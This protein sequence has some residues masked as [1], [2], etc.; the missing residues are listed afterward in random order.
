MALNPFFLNGTQSEQGLVQ[1]LINEQLRMYGIEC[2]YMP[3]S[4]VTS[5]TVLQEVIQSEF[6]SAFPLEAYMDNY[7]GYLGQG[8]ILSKF[9]IEDKDDLTLIISRERYEN[10]IAPL[11]KM[12]EDEDKFE[13][14]DRPKEGDLIYFPLGERLFEIKFVEHEKPFYQLKKNYVYTLTCELFRY[15]D[16]LIDTDI[17]EIDDEVAQIGYIQTLTMVGGGTTATAVASYCASG[18]VSQIY[19]KNM[20]KKYTK[21]PIVG[22]T[23][24]PDG[25][26]TASGIASITNDY[27][28]C[29]GLYGGMIDAILLTNAGCGYTVPPMVTIQS[30]SGDTG[31]GAAVT[32]GITTEGNVRSVQVLSGGTGYTSAPTVTFNYSGSQPTGFVTATGISTIS[33]AGI[34][35][36][37][38]ITNSGNRYGSNPTVVLSDPPSFASGIGTTNYIFNEVI[39]GETSGTTARVK[40]WNIT[41]NLLEV[42]IVDGDF[43]PGEVV[44]GGE[45][46]ARFILGVQQEYDLVSG[47][48]DNDT[49]ELEAKDIIDFTQQNPFGMP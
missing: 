25:G 15:E 47:F 36:A 40:E 13:L 45:S 34:V 37:I 26:I 38:Y 9:G 39:T 44:V 4:Y 46:G 31:V 3:R 48:A 22:F 11:M 30:A 43:T 7:E 18:S 29:N 20:G 16:E 19:I 1:S 14:S 24:A 12:F 6:K 2:Y 5:K 49:I 35:T 23:S 8:T 33:A 17:V 32:A 21:N 28:Q 41:T 42:S 27:I 10:Y